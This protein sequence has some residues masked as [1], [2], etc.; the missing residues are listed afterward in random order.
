MCFRPRTLSWGRPPLPGLSH[1]V[2]GGTHSSRPLG[3]PFHLPGGPSWALVVVSSDSLPLPQRLATPPPVTRYTSPCD[4]LPLPQRLTTPP[5]ATRYP[6]PCLHGNSGSRTTVYGATEP[7]VGGR[8]RHSG[9][10]SSTSRN[11]I[12]LRLKHKSFS[13]GGRWTRGTPL[14]LLRVWRGPRFWDGGGD[15]Q[16]PFGVVVGTGRDR[17]RGPVETRRPT[18]KDPETGRGR[19]DTYGSG[20]EERP[21]PPV[22]RRKR[23]SRRVDGTVGGGGLWVEGALVWV[24]HPPLSWAAAVCPGDSGRLG[25][26]GLPDPGP[27]ETGAAQGSDTCQE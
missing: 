12:P 11:W 20:G 27:G 10:T 8:P 6:S 25:F 16:D 23:R 24:F 4:S 7:G 18:K 5:P 26:H 1:E 13:G 19:G 3:Y 17:G 14:V 2:P 22:K 9:R 15:T 21:Y